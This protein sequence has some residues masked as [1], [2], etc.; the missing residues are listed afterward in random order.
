MK[1]ISYSTDNKVI[2]LKTSHIHECTS[3]AFIKPPLNQDA[4]FSAKLSIL[5]VSLCL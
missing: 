3:K 2:T 4:T 1:S 5:V